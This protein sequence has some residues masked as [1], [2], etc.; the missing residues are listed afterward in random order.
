MAARSGIDRPNARVH[1][2][3]CVRT[4]LPINVAHAHTRGPLRGWICIM[5]G[6]GPEVLDHELAH[7]ALGQGHT[8]AWTA[9]LESWGYAVTV[10]RYHQQARWTRY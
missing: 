3:G 8:R 10:P 4:G 5:P 7:L 2:G 9:L 6:Y 1:V